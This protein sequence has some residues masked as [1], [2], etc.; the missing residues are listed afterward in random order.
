M[1]NPAKKIV[2]AGHLYVKEN[3]LKKDNLT[4]VSEVRPCGR[5]A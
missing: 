2:P 5:K 3:V 4:G 1:G